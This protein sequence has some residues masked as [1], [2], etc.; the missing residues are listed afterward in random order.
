MLRILVFV[1]AAAMESFWGAAQVVSGQEGRAIINLR[2]QG[3]QIL[4]PYFIQ[5]HSG[6]SNSRWLFPGYLFVL[7]EQG[8]PWSAISNTFGV[9]R[10]LASRDGTP[11]RAPRG[12]CES[13]SRCLVPN[14]DVPYDSSGYRQLDPGTIVK[15]R[16]GPFKDFGAVVEWSSEQRLGLFFRMFG[17]DEVH[18]EVG[19]GDVE[20]DGVTREYS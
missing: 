20:V 7:L 8:M 15:I 13:L 4:A 18:I 11:H 14:P 12:F 16:S 5:H 17:R 6:S 2:R 1:L 3:F 9:V 19:V 10:L